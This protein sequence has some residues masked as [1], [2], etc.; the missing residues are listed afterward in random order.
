MN[1]W[2]DICHIPQYNFYKNLIIK[3]S[4]DGHKVFVTVLKR[5][6]LSQIVT[7]ELSEYISIGIYIIGVHRSNK[8]SAIFEGNIV[9]LIRLFYW[10]IGKKINVVLSN[11]FITGIIASC[12]RI[13]SYAFGDDIRKFDYNLKSLF[14]DGKN[15]KNHTKT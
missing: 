5:G 9:R 10:A 8:F 3:L 6:K 4:N 1:I 2:I 15:T 14:N 12:L 11:N 13:K 7:K